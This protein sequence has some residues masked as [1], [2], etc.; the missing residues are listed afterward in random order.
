MIRRDSARRPRL[1]LA[2]LAVVLATGCGPPPTYS[3]PRYDG[4]SSLGADGVASSV[5]QICQ[6]AGHTL[7][8]TLTGTADGLP[9]DLRFEVFDATTTY[10]D[11]VHTLAVDGWWEVRQPVPECFTFRITNVSPGRESVMFLE[12]WL[13]PR[14]YCPPTC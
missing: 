12:R 14:D 8:F 5:L 2:A 6:Q 11:E 13:Y 10:Y 7:R 1:L 3:G 9:V 4:G